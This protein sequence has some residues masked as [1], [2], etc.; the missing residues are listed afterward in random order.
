[1]SFP[2]LL[3]FFNVVTQKFKIT[4][5]AHIILDSTPLDSGLSLFLKL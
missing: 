1:M 4:N 2:C 5:M 3:K